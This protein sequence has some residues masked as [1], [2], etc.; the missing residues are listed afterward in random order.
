MH[1]RMHTRV[2]ILTVLG[3]QPWALH[4]LDNYSTLVRQFQTLMCP[5]KAAFTVESLC[6][7]N[8]WTHAC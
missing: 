1:A 8:S 6:S 5:P 7:A 3:I 4:K 2:H